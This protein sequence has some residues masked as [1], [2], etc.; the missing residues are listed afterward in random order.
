ME[1]LIYAQH[2]EHEHTVTLKNSVASF[3]F[4]HNYYSDGLSYILQCSVDQ[5]GY[6]LIILR[7]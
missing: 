1:R 6:Y 3:S 5:I 7:R 4:V 2:N